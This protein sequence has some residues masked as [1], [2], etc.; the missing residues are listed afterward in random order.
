[1]L[2]LGGWSCGRDGITEPEYD[3]GRST[4]IRNGNVGLPPTLLRDE[5]A[6]WGPCG[7]SSRPSRGRF[8]VLLMGTPRGAADES[9]SP[10]MGS[11]G[12]DVLAL[13]ETR[14]LD[15]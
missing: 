10:E 11:D 5:G 2:G 14:R 4:F 9:R 7:P 12:E 13:G 8:A 1:M 6:D 15:R 3:D